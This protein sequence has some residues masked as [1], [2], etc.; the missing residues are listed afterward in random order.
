VNLHAVNFSSLPA[1]RR[2][3]LR[4]LRTLSLLLAAAAVAVWLRAPDAPTTVAVVPPPPPPLAL[5]EGELGGPTGPDTEPEPVRRTPLAVL[6]PSIGVDAPIV[7]VGLLPGDVMEIPDDVAEIGW[8]DPDGLGVAP[9]LAGTA[10]LAGHVDS[11]SQGRG[12]LYDLRRLAVGDPI[13]V[14]LE[15]GTRSRWRVTEV[16]RYP[17]ATLP[18]HEV[19]TWSGPPR[20]ALITCGGEFDRTERSYLDN[21]VAYAEPESSSSPPA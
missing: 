18:Y 7:P 16:V 15:D 9:G 19:F 12:A 8:Y 4:L 10:V 5:P 6:V 14:V 1:R 13:E 21:I 3:Q 20:L 17:K 2:Q 11:R